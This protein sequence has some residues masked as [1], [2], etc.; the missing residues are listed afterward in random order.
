M[1]AIANYSPLERERLAFQPP[2]P[3]VFGAGA[4][5]LAGD[6]TVARSPSDQAHL[7]S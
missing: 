6:A 2:L 3:A 7:A 5:L 1:D 4:A